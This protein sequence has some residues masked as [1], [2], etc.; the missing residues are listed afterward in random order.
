MEDERKHCVYK[1]TSPSGKC[2]IGVSMRPKQRWKTHQ[3]RAKHGYV[4]RFYTAMRKHQG[5]MTFEIILSNLTEDEAYQAEITKITE[6]Q[7]A[8]PEH[9]YN[10]LLG[11]KDFPMTEEMIEANKD[12][13]RTDKAKAWRL[14]GYEANKDDIRKAISDGARERSIALNRPFYMYHAETDVLLQFEACFQAEEPTGIRARSIHSM[15]KYGNKNNKGWTARLIAD[16]PDLEA[17]KEWSRSLV[18]TKGDRIGMKRAKA[19]GIKATNIQTGEVRTYKYAREVREDLGGR[20]SSITR[21]LNGGKPSIFGWKLEYIRA[22]T[23]N[24]DLYENDCSFIK[25][26]DK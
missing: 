14:A 23:D 25:E 12:R 17:F 13:L 10:T 4:S 15:V 1:V 18:G 19:I 20:R 3:R 26:E 8:D 11:G 16:T 5:Q 6:H 24:I 7:A 22:Q 9:G 2:Y 21:V